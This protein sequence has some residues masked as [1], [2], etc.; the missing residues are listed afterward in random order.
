MNI[1]LK[2]KLPYL[3]TILI[4]LAAY[5]INNII[6]IHTDSPIINYSFKEVSSKLDNGVIH[7]EWECTLVNYNRKKAVKDLNLQIAYKSDLPNP[8]KIDRP[9]IIPIAPSAI[10]PDTLT[11]FAYGLI[12]EYKIPIIH[13]HAK[14]ILTFETK[15]NPA[16]KELPKIYLN[17]NESIRLIEN[18]LEVFLIKNQI[19]LNVILLL[20]WLFFAIYYLFYLTKSKPYKNES[21]A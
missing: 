12:N 20:F 14:Y 17:T 8:K 2:E 4:G 15:T 16:I 18:N 1:F 11:S 3:L 10:L 13:P 19:L 9:N 7:K 6:S 5:Q 21:P